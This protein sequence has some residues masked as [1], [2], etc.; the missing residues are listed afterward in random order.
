MNAQCKRVTRC[1]KKD[2]GQSGD[3]L[4]EMP[5]KF[6][7]LTYKVRQKRSDIKLPVSDL[8]VVIVNL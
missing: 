2:L 7:K 1:P 6:K 3:T 8:I 5:E 4:P